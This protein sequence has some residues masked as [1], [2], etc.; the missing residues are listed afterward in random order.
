M[1]PTFFASEVEG[2]AAALDS[3]VVA[4]PTD[5]RSLDEALGRV[6]ALRGIS[7]LKDLP[8]LADVAD[9]IEHAAKHQH[10]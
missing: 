6:R 3:F 2:V 8:P 7:A 9:A 4:A 5:R 10:R 1:S